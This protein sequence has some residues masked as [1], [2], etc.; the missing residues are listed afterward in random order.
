MAHPAVVHAARRADLA[1]RGVPRR[2][3]RAPR[4][5]H[6]SRPRRRHPH[7]GARRDRA[8]HLGRR[9]HHEAAR[10]AGQRPRQA[11]RPARRRTRHRARVP[12][13]APRPAAVGCRARP[14]SA[15]S[16]RSACETVGDLAAIPED[17]LVRDA[18][19]R[20]RPPSAR[21][22]VE[23]R[24]AP[25]RAR[26]GG[27][28]D[29]ARG[30]LPGRPA[31]PRRARA[32]ASCGLADGVA[33]RLRA[34]RRRRPDGAAQGPLRRLHAPSPGRA[35]SRSRPTSPPT[36][37]GSPASSWVPSTSFL[38]CACWASRV[39]SWC[40]RH[41]NL[42][43]QGQLFGDGAEA[44]DPAEAADPP[45]GP[46]RRRRWSVRSMRCGPA[47]APVPSGR[48]GPRASLGK[49]RVAPRVE[50]GTD[51]AREWTGTTRRAQVGAQ[52]EEP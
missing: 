46:D 25:G 22:G 21:A 8:H 52:H 26:P 37:A 2:R 13:P 34:A 40:G 42:E 17:T 19:Q 23:P 45:P 16:A 31:R 24:R 44:V 50:R 28:V 14:P 33:S 49:V 6:R 41:R 48:G 35:R 32:P 1:R 3:R 43:D 18:R 27:E 15:S 4:A 36:S 9:R 29:R 12:A 47:S 38:A 20:I 10:Q 7:A 51:R 5:R 30:D 39:S 11:R